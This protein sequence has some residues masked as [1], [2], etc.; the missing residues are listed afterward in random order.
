M[1]DKHKFIIDELWILAWGA[2]VQRANL[3][4]KDISSTPIKAKDF[5]ENI[6][7]FVR[8]K[9]VPQYI[10]GCNEEQHYKNIYLLITFANKANPGILKKSGYKYGVAQKLLNLALKYY[11][12]LGLVK[13][14][15]HCPVD[16]KVINKTTHKGKIN[17]TE[18]TKRSEYRKIIED[19]K[20]IARKEGLSISKWEFTIFERN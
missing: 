7:G 20:T 2:S 9:I 18:I 11:W 10:I 14:P 15:P 8:N 3:Y 6:I 19:I 1:D 5:R 13:E 17:W 12:C 4:K 16:R